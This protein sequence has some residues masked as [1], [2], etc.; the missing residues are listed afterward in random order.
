[1]NVYE[2][3]MRPM[4]WLYGCIWWC[5]GF[6]SAN[7][8]VHEKIYAG[9]M[10]VNCSKW[11]VYESVLSSMICVWMYMSQCG[12]YMKSIWSYKKCKMVVKWNVYESHV[13]V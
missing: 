8:D 9:L 2:K 5:M 13:M 1:M 7:M 10:N 12:R 6:M 3:C 11:G 4:W